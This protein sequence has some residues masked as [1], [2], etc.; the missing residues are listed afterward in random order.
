[1]NYSEVISRCINFIEKNLDLD[2]SPDLIANECG[3]S[4]FHFCIIFNACQG[5]PLMEYVKKRRLSLSAEKLFSGERIIDI[6]ME[7]GFSTHNGYTKA[8][9]KEFGYSPVQYIK[10]MEG[11]YSE[12]SLYDIGGYIMDPVIVKRPGFKIAGY[13]IE[14]K[15][16]DGNFTKDVAS[17]WSNYEGE[18]LETKMYKILKP[19]KHGEVGVCVPSKNQGGN[20]LYLLGVIVKDFDLVTE[21]MIT[22]EIPEATYAVFTTPPV[23]TSGDCEDD[24]FA[25][26]IRETWKYIFKEWFKDNNYIFD[27]DKIDFE[28]YD[29]RCHWRKDSVMDIYVPVI[30]K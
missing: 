28:F 10:R 8:F 3:Y 21:D 23:D 27:E 4:T 15:I 22:L 9:K 19:E 1:M 13:G 12:N 14:T 7:C 6:A 24:K 16:T 20:A 2:L 18:N 11:Y 26:T 29:E 5:I 25:K 17:F 30:E